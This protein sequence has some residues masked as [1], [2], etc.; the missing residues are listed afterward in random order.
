[1]SWSLF[2][3][4]KDEL[5]DQVIHLLNKIDELGIK[6]KFIRCYN[7]PEN[8]SL[9]EESK[10]LKKNIIFEYTPRDTPQHNVIVEMCFQTL[11]QSMRA[12]I[13]GAGIYDYLR[14]KF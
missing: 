2:V 4:S 9:Y 10:R 11:Y 8:K 13:N 14:N 6:I 5:S 7:S 1:M 12:M 3:K